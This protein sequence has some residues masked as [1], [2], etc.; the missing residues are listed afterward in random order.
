MDIFA[1]LEEHGVK[2]A[3]ATYKRSDYAKS[4]VEHFGF[5]KYTQNICGADNDNKLK[6]RDILCNC[7]KNEP[8]FDRRSIVMIGDA[9]SDGD[10]AEECGVDFLAVR[11]GYG[12]DSN[13]TNINCRSIGS[14]YEP[15]EIIK[16]YLGLKMKIKLSD[17]VAKFA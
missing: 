1:E 4:I 9:K 8:D 13:S 2:F 14:V 6:K 15:R 16:F 10:A 5:C 12:F 17:Y 3:I 7:L 11:Y